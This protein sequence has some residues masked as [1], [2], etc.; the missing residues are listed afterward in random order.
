MKKNEGNT[1]NRLYHEKEF[2]QALKDCFKWIEETHGKT[3]YVNPLDVLIYDCLYY[4]VF[5]MRSNGKTTAAQIVALI[6]FL[7]YGEPCAVIRRFDE[8]IKASRAAMFFGVIDKL[9]LVEH[10][11]GGEWQ[12]IYYYNGCF[13]LAKTD[14]DG[15]RI[16]QQRPFGY[17]FALTQ[18]QHD[19]GQTFPG[20]IGTAIFDEF[21][22]RGAYLPDEFTLFCNTLSTILR[23]DGQ[24]KVWMLGNTV[25][26]YCPYF[27]EMGL[28][29]LRDME[30][31]DISTYT[32]LREDC[33]VCVFYSD[34]IPGGKP[35]D[36]Y[37]AFDNPKL[38]MITE[39]RFEM[40][41]YPHCPHE[42][43]KRDILFSF[44]FDFDGELLRGDV[45]RTDED[46]G[47]WVFI[48][49]K[50]TELK[51]PD[52]DLIY[53]DKAN[54]RPNWARNMSK[55]RTRSERAIWM[56]YQTGKFFYADNQCG[57]T[58]RTYLMTCGYMGVR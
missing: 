29:H 19:K 7:L 20:N 57:E 55:P 21:M 54:H 25:S 28:K 32:G 6:R 35:T 31:G 17:T 18:W 23:D 49:P 15:K 3:G 56:L 40:A 16:K 24:T 11:T 22:T 14:E 41:L 33:N 10:L 48:T 2:Y 9:G 53:S 39:G 4:I 27:R 50:T 37:F 47:E 34:G 52:S 38:R 5:G 36:K 45:I 26:Y 43:G 44:F 13:Y 1:E 46:N 8:D 42:F 30:P 12:T 58:V 51:A